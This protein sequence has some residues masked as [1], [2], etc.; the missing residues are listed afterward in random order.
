VIRHITMWKVEGAGPLDRGRTAGEIR[1]L[2]EALPDTVP[3]IRSLEVGV[4]Q[5]PGDQASDVVL[6]TEFDDWEALKAYAIHPAHV[7]VAERV[8]RLTIERMSADYE[9]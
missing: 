4:N 2:L 7:E 6:V 1:A 8:R 3:G 9:V 5:L